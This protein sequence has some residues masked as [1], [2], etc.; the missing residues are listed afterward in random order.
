MYLQKFLNQPNVAG[1]VLVALLF[2]AGVVFAF[3]F[4]GFDVQ[5]I[6]EDD[7]NSLLLMTASGCCGGDQD[8]DCLGVTGCGCP[9]YHA[10]GNQT[11]TDVCKDGCTCNAGGNMCCNG[12]RCES[13]SKCEDKPC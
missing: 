1:G 8:C 2:G 5:S 9:T 4:G 13:D 7:V 10:C 6:G 12:I 11:S 3:G